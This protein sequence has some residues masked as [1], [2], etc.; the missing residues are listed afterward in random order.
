M[1]PRL[2]ADWPALAGKHSVAIDQFVTIA[3]K[4]PPAAWGQ[5]LASG[6]WTPAEVTSHLVES[7]RI[8][9]SELAGGTGMALRLPRLRCWLLRRT[10]LPGIL[11]RGLFPTGARA[12]RET[13]P[14]EVIA[15][16]PSA[17]A[18]LTN[19][20]S[21]FVEELTL[22][23]SS[24]RIH[25][26]HAYFGPMSPRQSLQLVAVHALHHARQLAALQPPP[27]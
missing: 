14:R 27:K 15:D 18:A 5:P 3:R 17:L 16:I 4:L 8:L 13:R 12:P 1:T 26:T 21:A 10:L 9:R 7:Y 20:A 25:L 22:R 19:Q 24:G 6:K 11:D 2:P 23:A